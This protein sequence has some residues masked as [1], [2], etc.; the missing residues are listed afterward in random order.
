[1]INIDLYPAHARGYLLAHNAAT[2]LLKNADIKAFSVSFTHQ[3]GR[4]IHVES[5][6][7]WNPDPLFQEFEGERPFAPTSN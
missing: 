1:M 3:T 6:Q 7:G 4:M 2:E 5:E